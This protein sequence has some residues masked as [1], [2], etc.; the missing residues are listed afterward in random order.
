MM[1][2][3]NKQPSGRQFRPYFPHSSAFPSAVPFLMA[4]G[5]GQGNFIFIL[6]TVCLMHVPLQLRLARLIT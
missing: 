2:S 6:M 1:H 5:A 3:N 4:S